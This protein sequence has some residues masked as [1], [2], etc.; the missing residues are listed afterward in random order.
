[1]ARFRRKSRIA[2]EIPTGPMADISFLLVIFFMVTTVFVVY[3]GFQVDLPSAELIEP[4]RSRRNVVNV[5]VSSEGAIMVDEYTA[6]IPSL[7]G[8]VSSKLRNNP[9]IIVQV[10][11]DR[12][13]PY[14]M[15]AQVIEELKKADAL[16]VSFVAKKEHGGMD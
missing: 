7:A 5:W 12:Q 3:R 6:D 13:T 4:L 10:K 8:I 11:S 14:R 15:I 2:Q 9:R 16:R 1:M